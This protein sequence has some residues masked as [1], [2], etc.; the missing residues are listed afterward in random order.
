[1]PPGR[2]HTRDELGQNQCAY[3]CLEGH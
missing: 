1:M 2:L 3:Y